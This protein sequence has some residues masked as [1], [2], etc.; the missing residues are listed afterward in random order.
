MAE[1]MDTTTINNN[2]ILATNTSDVEVSLSKEQQPEPKLHSEPQPLLDIFEE[3]DVLNNTIQSIDSIKISSEKEPSS[4]PASPL[5]V[6]V[7]ELGCEIK[8]VTDYINPS[9]VSKISIEEDTEGLLRGWGN[10]E[11]D[12]SQEVEE[13]VEENKRE[14][15]FKALKKASV[16]VTGTALVVAGIP[17]IPMPT[18]GGVIVCGSGLAVLATEFPAA[19]RVLD[20]G[21]NGLEKMVGKE[22]DDSDSDDENDGGGKN[23]NGYAKINSHQLEVEGVDG[24]QN[25]N[26][27]ENTGMINNK[28]SQPTNKTTEQRVDELKH[29]AR[30][31]GKQTK[32]NLKKFVRGTVLPFMDNFTSKNGE[33]TQEKGGQS[34]PKKKSNISPKK[35]E[36]LK[37][38]DKKNNI[39][40]TSPT[41]K[42]VAKER[43]KEKSQIATF[44]LTV[45]TGKS[46]DLVEEIDADLGS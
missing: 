12:N 40:L 8:D 6:T 3:E 29:N 28:N 2:T 46:A 39:S 14:K 11:E 16:A 17:L 45:P 10:E 37:I 5:N 31:A 25:L 36:I 30:K 35:K 21:R 4:P 34:S 18:P 1:D 42:D 32:K 13:E 44:P 38:G 20:K 26:Q 43:R 27:N 19:Q 15:A 33:E 9:P 23:H 41:K 22:E 24:E 7:E